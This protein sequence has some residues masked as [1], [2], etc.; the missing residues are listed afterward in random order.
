MFDVS[1]SVLSIVIPSALILF[2]LESSQYSTHWTLAYDII[3]RAAAWLAIGAGIVHIGKTELDNRNDALNIILPIVGLALMQMVE[4]LWG[5]SYVYITANHRKQ[6]Y[7]GFR[8]QS[9]ILFF[10][11]FSGLLLVTI[12][13]A[14]ERPAGLQAA[15]IVGA[16][17]VWMGHTWIKQMMLDRTTKEEAWPHWINYT[18]YLMYGIGLQVMGLAIYMW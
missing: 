1:L 5:F 12:S 14:W 11:W 8:F 17:A 13:L 10:L 6:H 9:W 18:S 3:G 15:A 7:R 2:H 16:W 4:V